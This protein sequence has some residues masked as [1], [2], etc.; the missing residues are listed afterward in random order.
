MSST[1]FNL[2]GKGMVVDKLA[3]H[4]AENFQNSMNILPGKKSLEAIKRMYGLENDLLKFAHDPRPNAYPHLPVAP[5]EP[6]L[7]GL[8]EEEAQKRIEEYN[9]TKHFF[10]LVHEAHELKVPMGAYMHIMK[11]MDKYKRTLNAAPA[12]KGKRFFAL[13]KNVA[14]DK[15]GGIFGSFM[16]GD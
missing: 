14:E 1:T 8:T 2:D 4:D 12:I 6:N 9:R 10:D 16:S 13:T 7:E 5:Q 11:Y 3:S 15:K